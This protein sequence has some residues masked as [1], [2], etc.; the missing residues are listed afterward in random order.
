MLILKDQCSEQHHLLV[1]L[2]LKKWQIH[3]QTEKHGMSKSRGLF[4]VHLNWS[5]YSLTKW[6]IG[7]FSFIPLNVLMV[8]CKCDEVLSFSRGVLE[9]WEDSGAPHVNEIRVSTS[10]SREATGTFAQTAV[11]CREHCTTCKFSA[12]WAEVCGLVHKPSPSKHQLGVITLLKKKKTTSVCV[13]AR[14]CGI[15]RAILTDTRSTGNNEM[16]LSFCSLDNV[17]VTTSLL[18]LE[19]T[20]VL[21]LSCRSCPFLTTTLS[22][23]S[24]SFYQDCW[25]LHCFFCSSFIHWNTKQVISQHEWWKPVALWSDHNL[26][27]KLSQSRQHDPVKLRSKIPENMIEHQTGTALTGLHIATYTLQLHIQGWS[28]I[29]NTVTIGTCGIK[30]IDLCRLLAFL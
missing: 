21:V 12:L 16:S 10:K 27:L 8:I 13:R 24:G 18:W 30:N 9:C 22:L 3:I 23:T 14:V 11:P 29:C 25:D 5:T 26:R 1:N 4:F 15:S 28:L 6:F 7:D 2:Y 19:Q 20:N 17:E